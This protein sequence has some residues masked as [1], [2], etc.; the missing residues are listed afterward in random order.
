MVVRVTCASDAVNVRAVLPPVLP[1]DFARGGNGRSLPA[2][3]FL[4]LVRE[5][6]KQRVRGRLRHV[7]G[8]GHLDERPAER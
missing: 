6:V 7:Q 4:E 8:A 5:L 2:E 1:P 3:A